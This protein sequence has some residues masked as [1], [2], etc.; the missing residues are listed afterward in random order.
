MNISALIRLTRWQ[1]F[2]PFTT[3]LTWLGGLVAYRVYDVQLD[4]RLWVALLANL[5]AVAYAFM[6]N[7]IEDAADDARDPHRSLVNPITTQEL[8][9]RAAW[10]AS[11]G[12]ATISAIAYAVC[13]LIPFV[14]GISTLVLAHLYSWKPV[15]LK[16]QPLIDIISHALMLSTLLF[17]AP[18]YIYADNL[19]T[20]W[21]IT[22]GTFLISANGQL[23]NQARDFEVDQLAGLHNTASVLGQ[24]LTGYLST[25]TVMGFAICLVVTVLQGV[26]PLWL[27][28]AGIVAIPVVWFLYRN[29]TTD[30]RGHET[31]E[32]VGLIQVQALLVANIIL[33][34]WLIAVLL[35]LD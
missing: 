7:E 21:V 2:V 1:E 17:L 5:G 14:I 16:A 11:L 24:T 26:F 22:V 27:A 25:G 6:V 18:F 34:V 15:R 31:D 13:G 19:G 29:R 8:S 35:N 30:M 3:I 33:L 23:Y 20:L 10:G 4:W 9:V 32:W 12:V 28:G